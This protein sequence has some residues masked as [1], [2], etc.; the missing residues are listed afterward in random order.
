MRILTLI[1]ALC[2]GA[3]PA[4]G[5]TILRAFVGKDG[6]VHVVERGGAKRIFPPEPRQVGVQQI[7][8]SPDRRAVG[9]TVLNYGC[10]TSYEVPV[11]LDLYRNGK[12][13]EISLGGLMVWKWRFVG[14]GERVAVLYG[15]AHGNADG[16]NLYNTRNGKV[17]AS[18]TSPCKAPPWASLW[19][20]ELAKGPDTDPE[21]SMPPTPH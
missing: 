20:A 17:I 7:H 9:W 4:Q 12:K 6:T 18:C 5:Q 8:I 14:R 10:C 15:P 1:L 3:V 21:G 16:A 11:S 2:F 13:V 19:Q